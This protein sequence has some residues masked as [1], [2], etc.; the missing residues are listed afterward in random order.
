MAHVKYASNE[1]KKVIND[2][3]F[4]IGENDVYFRLTVVDKNNKMANTI[5]YKVEDYIK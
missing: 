5:A 3:S 2:A 4:K 1:G